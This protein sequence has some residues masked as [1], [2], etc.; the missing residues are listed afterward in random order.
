MAI[1]QILVLYEVDICYWVHETKSWFQA[2]RCRFQVIRSRFQAR[3][4]RFQAGWS[5]F[6]AGRSRFQAG[7]YRFQAGLSRFLAG[8]KIVKVALSAVLK[9]TADWDL[10]PRSKPCLG[11]PLLKK[12]SKRTDFILLPKYQIHK[13]ENIAQPNDLAKNSWSLLKTKKYQIGGI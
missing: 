1:V 8:R 4:S 6:Q 12:S 3:R 11:R 2:G 5:R 7:R 9:P 10:E 13:I